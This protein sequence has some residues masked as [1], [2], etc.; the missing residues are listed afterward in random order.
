MIGNDEQTETFM[1]IAM[2]V[3]HFLTVFSL[4]SLF[5]P[6]LHTHIYAVTFRTM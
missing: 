2:R 4:F 3:S 1:T 5:D 6:E